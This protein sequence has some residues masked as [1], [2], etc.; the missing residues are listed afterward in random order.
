[1]NKI[2]LILSLCLTTSAFA[3]WGVSGGLT[4]PSFDN[5]PSNGEYDSTFGFSIAGLYDHKLTNEL[6]LSANIGYSQYLSD[7]TVGNQTAEVTTSYLIIRP[8]IHYSIMDVFTVFGGFTYGLN[9]SAEYEFSGT[10]T[11]YEDIPG[12]D[13]NN[14][15]A[16]NFGAGYLIDLSGLMLRPT[17]SYELGLNDAIEGNGDKVTFNS[18]NFG[19]DLLF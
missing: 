7:W 10:T 16:L 1:M 14:R 13:V 12:V 2:I 5:D 11:K 8:L 3:G 6:T 18:L 19:I 15:F 9:M 17:I 4:L